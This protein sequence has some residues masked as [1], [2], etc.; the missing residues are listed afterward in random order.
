MQLVEKELQIPVI[1]INYED[2]KNELDKS[3][4]E[5]KGLVVTDDTLSGCK[6]AQKELASLRTMVDTY[7]KDKKKELSAPIT[8]FE[9]QCKELVKMIEAVE[10]P[11]KDGIKV[12]DDMK[13]EE[14]KAVAE[15]IIEEVANNIGLN[16]KYK[17]QL[18]VIDKYMNLTTTKKAVQED[19]ETRAFALKVEQDREEER[20][21]IINSV[22][23]SEN[24][25]INTKLDISQFQSLI[26]IGR[27]TSEI[28][29][30]VKNRASL[31]YEA[32][33]KPKETP[34]ET[35]FEEPEEPEKPTDE[36]K[37]ED[38]QKMFTATF[39]VVGSADELRSVSGFLKTHDI[40]Y[41]VLEQKAVV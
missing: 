27:S 20:L 41:E 24:K 16:D 5:Y 35:K 26:N 11:I 31:I 4:E 9:N 30:E 7:R 25:R 17:K 28:I 3:L 8:V 18:T 21:S 29:E 14:K 2:L 10:A 22:I 36:P 32:E 40:T 1:K 37:K 39:K 19:V 13:R 15:Q 34:V 23:D 12:F 33:N 38:V 6:K